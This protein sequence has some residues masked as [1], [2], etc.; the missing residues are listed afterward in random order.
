MTDLVPIVLF[1]WIPL[2]VA[3]FAMLPARRAVTA[4]FIVGWLF[5]PVAGYQLPG[6]LDYTKTTATSIGIL[7]GAGVFDTGRLLR[8][9]VRWIDAPM[10]AWCACP[11]A[12]SLAN[13]LGAYDGMATSFA[14]LAM[15]GVPYFIGRLYFSELEGLRELA[16]GIMIGGLAY[17][18]LCLLE[19]RLSPQLHAWLYGYHQAPFAHH[20][21]F[22]G[23][24]P[25]VFLESGL[26]LGMWMTAASVIGVSL[27]KSNGLRRIGSIPVSA[28]TLVLITTAALCKAMG[29][30]VLLLV[31]V[32]SLFATDIV[33]RSVVI[34]SLV[35]V[36]PAYIVA[37]TLY[38]WWPY[39]VLEAASAISPDRADSLQFRLVHEGQLAAHAM[40][41]PIFGWGGWGRHRVID[42]WGV[43]QSITDGLW[44]IVLG[45][46]GMFGLAALGAALLVP[47][48]ML[49]RW[50]AKVQPSVQ[51]TAPALSLAIIV[52]LFVFDSLVNAN[53][54]PVFLL[55]VGGLAG[56]GV[57]PLSV[58]GRSLGG[59]NMD[60]QL[61]SAR[62]STI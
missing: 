58:A 49:G 13:G 18:P 55:A 32:A 1:G 34:T 30:L 48:F 44:V 9:R 2:V 39:S 16:I 41:R 31:G 29:A 20:L 12:S 42:E 11:L 36:P 26:A 15:W 7:L 25:K 17:V 22:G 54:N 56:L 23:Y 46:N 51:A 52:I 40:E 61:S 45:K 28:L 19:I 43:D 50:L 33:R 5:L 57:G 62:E 4:A 37:R 60:S 27:W 6:L 8:F 35:L 38:H 21:R 14:A 3:L 59:D 47:P 10:I 24:R 53:Q